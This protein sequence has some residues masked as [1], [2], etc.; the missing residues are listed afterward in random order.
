MGVNVSPIPSPSRAPEVTLRLSIATKISLAFSMMVIVFTIVIMASIW[1]T[2]QLFGQIQ[3][4]NQSIIPL[5]LILSDAQNDLKSFD[6]ALSEPEP[7]NLRRA[8]QL[9]RMMARVPQRVFTKLRK[10]SELSDNEP[11]T[12]MAEPERLRLQDIQR[13]LTRIVETASTLDADTHHLQTLLQQRQQSSDKLAL[14]DAIQI[15]RAALRKKTQKLDLEL[16]RVRNDLRI[17][18]DLALVRANQS[19]R[20]N[21]YAL[22]VMSAIALLVTLTMFAVALLTV[23]PLGALTEGV[24]QIARGEYHTLENRSPGRLGRDEIATLTEEFNSMA[25]AL[26]ARDA[27]LREQHDALLKAERLATIGRMTSLITHELRNPLSSIGLNA[28]MIIAQLLELEGEEREDALAGLETII[29]EVDRLRDI[30]EEY[31]V[32]AR[33]PEPK[34]AS[35]DLSELLE[36]I[37]D[38]HEWEWGQEGVEVELTLPD[39]PVILDA[40]ANQLRQALLNLIKNAVEASSNT[41]DALVE[42]TL[43]RDLDKSTARV[44]IKDHG[45][46]IPDDIQGR[47]FEPFFTSKVK[48]T[49]LGLAM[50]QQIV[51]EHHGQVSHKSN[52]ERGT[53]FQITLPLPDIPT[54]TSEEPT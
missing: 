27:A 16:T 22:G 12:R 50:T 53:T 28:E 41:E 21:L 14:D 10:A 34:L 24:K 23:R 45:E 5:S 29:A 1:R 15:Q 3:A 49:G 19:E 42:V 30:T 47:I 8:L 38:F 13:K 36:Q 18:T 31:L 51:V 17:S 35:H 6:V 46:G 44:S 7:E 4:L 52:Q 2:Q 43:E 37:I 20:T 32:Y 11:L 26:D 33:L 48:G 54:P 25:R 39:E 9:T 40:D